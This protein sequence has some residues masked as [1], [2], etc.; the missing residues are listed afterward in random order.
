M[1]LK[2]L[3]AV[4][5]DADIR[6]ILDLALGTFGGFELTLCESGEAA[7]TALQ[8]ERPDLILLDVMMPGL[9][10]PGTLR[11]IRAQPA[12][13][14]IP[15]VFLTAKLQPGEIASWTALGALAVIGKPFDPLTLPDELR[16]L[17]TNH[18]P[19]TATTRFATGLP[20]ELEALRP[21]YLARV[22]RDLDRLEALA[23]RILSASSTADCRP[24]LAD[25]HGL[26]HGLAGSAG[27]FGYAELG[28]QCRDLDQ[29]SGRWLDGDADPTLRDWHRLAAD[30][31]LL[32]QSLR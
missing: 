2:K 23:S 9:D 7:L 24:G 8:Q 10:G 14:T 1:T 21:D 16:Q 5:D 3:M 30:L 26:L 4:E 15:V 31:L 22:H 13:A 19:H 32:R 20:P 29:Q 12:L 28:Q 6:R 25:L 11:A 17:Y 27:G 18:T